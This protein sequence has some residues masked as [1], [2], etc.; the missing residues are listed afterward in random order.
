MQWNSLAR[1]KCT[2]ASSPPSSVSRCTVDE[3]ISRHAFPVEL[4]HIYIPY[5]IYI[6][7]YSEFH[8]SFSANQAIYTARVKWSFHGG[9][10]TP[11]ERLSNN[12]FVRRPP[13]TKIRI[14][15]LCDDWTVFIKRVF[16]AP[17]FLARRERK[18]EI[19]LSFFSPQ[20]FS[21][22][23]L[24]T[25]ERLASEVPRATATTLISGVFSLQEWE[26]NRERGERGC[27]ILYLNR[28]S[29]SER[30]WIFIFMVVNLRHIKLT[31]FLLS[32]SLMVVCVLFFWFFMW[33]RHLLVYF[34]ICPIPR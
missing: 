30:L 34:H 1:W 9:T 6:Y 2:A 14:K 27:I 4:R 16:L 22:W 26:R 31:L 29:V 25:S 15:Y 13:R 23:V 24:Y 21:V 11:S 3:F 33:R 8:L 28:K 10:P 32:R 5:S 17:V 12:N 18:G 19:H 7:I 20:L